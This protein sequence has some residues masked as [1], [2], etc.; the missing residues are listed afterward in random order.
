MAEEF[1]RQQLDVFQVPTIDRL[2]PWD[3]IGRYAA[4][5]RAILNR[6][7]SRKPDA[8]V[9]LMPHIWSPL[10]APSIKR[11]GTKYLTVIHDAVPHKGDETAWLTAWLLRD[12]R[13]ADLIITLSR[14]V[15]ERLIGQKTVESSRILPMFHPDL[16]Y[17]A[18]LANRQLDPMQPFR[19]L[20]FGRIMAYKG[21]PLL[22]DAVE[23]LLKQGFSIKL[24]VAGSGP[25]GSLRRRL[26]AIGAEIDNR[27][28]PDHEVGRYLARYDAMV[29]SHLEASQS[30]VAAA[31][32]GSNMPVI[33]M[34]IGGLT[35]QVIDQKTGI[36]ARRMTAISL[37]D[38]IQRLAVLPGLYDGISA[39]LTASSQDRSMDRFLNELIDEIRA[40]EEARRM[41]R[42]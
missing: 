20:F 25:L 2:T 6:L 34:P 14:A 8:V 26:E 31:A 23:T 16:S 32:F 33:A 41:I 19:V 24:G 21:L 9:T 39:S 42:S 7:A 5:R 28:I 12:A 38:A 15:A 13:H 22:I 17:G 37:A 18:S 36:L 3:V 27:W 10:M 29:C 40:L 35:E 1:R 30:G 4:A 11:L